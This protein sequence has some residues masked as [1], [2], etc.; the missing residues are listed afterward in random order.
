MG[1]A[2]VKGG[3]RKSMIHTP[4]MEFVHGRKFVGR[5]GW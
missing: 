1:R 4:N 3:V 5:A 2:P